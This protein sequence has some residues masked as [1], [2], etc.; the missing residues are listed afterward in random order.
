[1]ND[2]P[3]RFEKL[4]II[5]DGYCNLCLASTAKLKELPSYAELHFIPIQQL[6]QAELD[7]QLMHGLRQVKLETLYEQIHVTDD[8]G[9]VYAGADGVIRILR[10]VKGFRW[11]SGIYRIPGMKRLADAMYRYVAKRRYDW[12]GRTEKSCSI[13]GC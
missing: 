2:K 5:Y 10:T 11:I 8:Q 9:H 3:R 1:M 12:F 4:F 6:D 13:Q 7:K